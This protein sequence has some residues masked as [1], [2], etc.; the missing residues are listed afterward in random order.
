MT[1]VARTAIPLAPARALE[2]AAVP[3]VER[4]LATIE[5]KAR[6]SGL[7]RSRSRGSDH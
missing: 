1:E 2:D 4:V 7:L 5:Q 6:F 3:S